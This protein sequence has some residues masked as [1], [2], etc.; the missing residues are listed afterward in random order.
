LGALKE[1]LFAL[2]TE[3]LSGRTSEEE[4]RQIKASLEVV[5]RQALERET[6][7]R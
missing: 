6:A 7:K 2:E 4:Y 5:L 3:R 1:A